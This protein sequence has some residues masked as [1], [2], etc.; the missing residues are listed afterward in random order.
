M[1]LIVS[2]CLYFSTSR[3]DGTSVSTIFPAV[4]SVEITCQVPAN[5]C[6]QTIPI[7]RRRLRVL[8]MFYF[9]N[10][11]CYV[12]FSKILMTITY[13]QPKIMSLC[14]PLA[15]HQTLTALSSYSFWN[16]SLVLVAESWVVISLNISWLRQNFYELLLLG[17][18]CY[19]VLFCVF[20]Q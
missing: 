8:S 14:E 17:F 18:G 11:W 9:V 6:Q 3:S 16:T 7:C 2:L 13:V 4:D 5:W 19:P 10:C 1:C 12:L 15:L 20:W